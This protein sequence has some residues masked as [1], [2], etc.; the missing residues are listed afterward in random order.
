MEALA[1]HEAVEKLPTKEREVIGLTYY[2]G[3]TQA[4]IAELFQVDERTIR[5]Y[6]Q[7][8]CDEL[9]EQLGGDLPS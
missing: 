7:Y 3:W 4:Q 1:F 9:R 8:A 5:R 6:Y 2:N